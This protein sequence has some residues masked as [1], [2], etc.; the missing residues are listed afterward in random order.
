MARKKQMTSRPR[1]TDSAQSQPTI[2][3]LVAQ[4]IER[5]LLLA[6]SKG[7]IDWETSCRLRLPEVVN[8]DHYLTG[9]VTAVCDCLGVRVDDLLGVVREPGGSPVMKRERSLRSDQL[10]DALGMGA[11]AG[12][13]WWSSTPE[14]TVDAWET[15][16]RSARPKLTERCLPAPVEADIDAM[17]A[18]GKLPNY[19]EAIAAFRRGWL[20]SILWAFPEDLQNQRP[21]RQ[22]PRTRVVTARGVEIIRRRP[23]LGM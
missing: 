17:V 18:S 4:E 9:Y 13:A 1:P 8:P 11:R 23:G 22:R 2:P 14:E 3:P 20:H 10:A 21:A 15:F 6:E 19:P 12:I 5:L 7:K 16:F